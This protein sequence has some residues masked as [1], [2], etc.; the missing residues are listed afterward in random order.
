VC[1]EEVPGSTPVTVDLSNLDAAAV[2]FR[3]HTYKTD[4]NL[5][6]AADS[7]MDPSIPLVVDNGTG[8]GFILR[9][10][11]LTYLSPPL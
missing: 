7:I 11:A 1:W 2:R 10:S 5:T 9:R 6:N 4:L 8:V 3:L